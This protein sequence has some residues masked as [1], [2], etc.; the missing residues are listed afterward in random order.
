VVR[1]GIIGKIGTILIC[2]LKNSVKS[3]PDS[4]NS[5]EKARQ[6]SGLQVHG[7]AVTEAGL[8]RG[9]DSKFYL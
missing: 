7:M 9:E 1:I 6:K 3:N 8:H 4:H 5:A 2:P